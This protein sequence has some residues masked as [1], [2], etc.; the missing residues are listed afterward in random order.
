MRGAPLSWVRLADVR[1]SAPPCS[2]PELAALFDDGPRNLSR[3]RQVDRAEGV[4][5][6]PMSHHP[7]TRRVILKGAAAA[8]GALALG[9]LLPG[10]PG[11]AQSKRPP[12][13]DGAEVTAWIVIE[14]TERVIVRV[15]RT[16]LGQGT[17]TGLAQLVA[18][19]LDCEWERVSVEFVTP[20]QNLARKRAWRDSVTTGS[21]GVRGSQEY[22]RLA[23]ATARAML[24]EAASGLFKAPQ[25]ELKAEKGMVRHEASGRALSYGRLAPIAARLPLPDPRVVRVSEPRD[26][27][28]SGKPLKSLNVA[29]KLTGRA[30]YGIDVKLPDMLAAAIKDSPVFGAKLNSVD[31]TEAERR[32]GVVRVVR[33]GETAVAVVA[34]TWWQARTALDA[35]VA[36]W[37]DV[38]GE[39]LD[40]AGIAANLKEGLDAAQGFIGTTHGDALKALRGS[41]KRVEAVYSLPYL[42]H[43]TL[44]PM[45]ATALWTPDRVEVWAATQNAE[46]AQ[47]AA[48]GAAGLPLAAAEIHSTLSGGAYG[49]RSR[50][51]Y[52]AQAVLIARQLPGRPIKLIWSR[53]EDTAHGFYRPATQ[54]KLTAGLDEKG[55]PA[56]LILR[57]SCQSIIA[58]SNPQA[59][60]Q[61]RDPRIFQSLNAEPGESQI[62]YSFPNLYIDHAMRTARVPVGSWRGVYSNANAIFLECFVDE[63]AKA[64]GRDPYDYRRGMMK[65]HA[66]HL[67]VLTAAGE[68]AGWGRPTEAGVHRG[69][70]QAMAY[71]SYAA[72]VAEVRISAEGALRV[73]R[74][75]IAIDCGHVVN[76]NLVTAQLE[77]SV[78][79]ALG[80]LLHQEITIQDGRVAEANF[81][82][83]PSLRLAEM[84]VVEPVLVPSGGFWGGVGEGAIAVVAPAVLNAIF[85]AT[86][87]RIRTLP[88]KNVR[89][90]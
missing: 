32:P 24:I 77:G 35:V 62:G 80:A 70:A 33:V 49:R 64:A 3:S 8:G 81:A 15:A 25:I 27:T 43:A 12:D 41:A 13:P 39:K 18:E 6:N 89:L 86:G 26:W 17:A 38:P 68:K 28:I 63:M 67:A 76:P 11:K 66:L 37:E 50:H 74:I 56:G 53:D 55:E 42:H 87:K 44:E 21:R 58:A 40:S 82:S 30:V 7:T 54:A 60:Q 23:G 78:A 88:L 75:V 5:S 79:F 71:G 85:A 34:E 52:I 45:T 51:D 83:F 16:E 31:A 20:G 90:I 84:P 29:D 46:A 22:M 48:A 19:E 57:I 4:R 59:L 61:G 65:A 10:A 36:T 9:I 2:P 69:I 1:A 14:P 73:E 47:R 72:T